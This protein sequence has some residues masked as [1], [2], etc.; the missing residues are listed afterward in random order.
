M[1]CRNVLRWHSL[2]KIKESVM[3]E[4]ELMLNFFTCESKFYRQE[5]V[6]DSN[7]NKRN[8]ELLL[9]NYKWMDLEVNR[10]HV[11]FNVPHK[12]LK[13]YQWWNVMKCDKKICVKFW[14]SFFQKW[15]RLTPMSATVVF[16]TQVVS[17][18]LQFVD[19]LVLIR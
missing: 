13:H 4:N 19:D 9:N 6:I 7:L 11:S 1:K 16:R 5:C 10:G 2:T 18:L 3:H 12:W 17:S 15:D 8:I 14:I